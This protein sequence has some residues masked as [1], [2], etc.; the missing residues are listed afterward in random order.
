MTGNQLEDYFFDR[1]RKSIYLSLS[2]FKY[3]FYSE[4]NYN[5]FVFVEG[6]TDKRFYRRNLKNSNK[7]RYISNG[8]DGCKEAVVAIANYFFNNFILVDHGTGYY[9]SFIIDKDYDD[10]Y[11]F[12][13]RY[14]KLDL[15][16]ITLLPVYSI[17][18]YYFNGQN[19]RTVLSSL[20]GVSNP[21]VIKIE[22]ELKK[23]HNNLSKYWAVKKWLVL[24]S[25][26]RKAF[27]AQMPKIESLVFE[28]LT[29]QHKQ[30]N[31]GKLKEIEV[32]LISSLNQKRQAEYQRMK[33]ELENNVSLVRGKD[34]IE[35]LILIC[36]YFGYQVDNYALLTTNVPIEVGLKLVLNSFQFTG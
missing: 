23:I 25:N 28:L 24:N 18:N 1:G 15:N 17:E 35:I 10:I 33:S 2:E 36:Q 13:S 19:L 11:F 30:P 9:L 14:P 12:P 6:K 31:M 21:I 32:S 5:H 4:E 3:F 27:G 16:I 20:L 26:A 22:G 29:E 7:T 34:L 8:K